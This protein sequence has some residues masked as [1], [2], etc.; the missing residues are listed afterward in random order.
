MVRVDADIRE[1]TAD[2]PVHDDVGAVLGACVD[3]LPGDAPLVL[4]PPRNRRRVRC[5]TSLSLSISNR[6]SL[7]ASLTTIGFVGANHTASSETC[8]FGRRPLIHTWLRTLDAA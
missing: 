1:C 5:S 4:V 3:D 8:S 6:S 2:R 7:D